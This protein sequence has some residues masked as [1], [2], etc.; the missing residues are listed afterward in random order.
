MAYFRQG[1]PKIGLQLNTNTSVWEWQDGSQLDWTYWPASYTE[2]PSDPS[3]PYMTLQYRTGYFTPVA[4]DVTLYLCE[5][6]P[7]GKIM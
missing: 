4:D 1:A 7:T 6:N 2:I 3:T 5:M